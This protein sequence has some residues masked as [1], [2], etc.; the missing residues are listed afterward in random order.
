MA[1]YTAPEPR[2]IELNL[3][4]VNQLFNSM[5]PSP[6]VDKDLDHNAEQFIVNWAQEY[7]P[8]EPVTLTIHLEH[9]PESDPGPLMT[10]AVHNFFA[11]RA[12]LNG[13][14]FRRLMEQGRTSLAIGLVFLAGCLL[15]GRVL[16]GREAGPWAGFLRE[17]L[18]IAGWVAM[19]RPMQMYLHDWWPVRRRG[20]TYAK[21]SRMP[22]EV[23]PKAR[24]DDASRFSAP[25]AARS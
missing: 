8:R 9:W 13:L 4:E 16:L 20:R 23:V 22:V 12:K 25:A 1:A 10:E 6:F 21:L 14:E 24:G 2:R 7:G 3:H 15:I 5:D 18:T 11:Y 19:W 17:S